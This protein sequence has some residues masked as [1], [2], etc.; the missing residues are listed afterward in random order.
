MRG[1][2]MSMATQTNEVDAHARP[3]SIRLTQASNGQPA[4]SIIGPIPLH[5]AEMYVK[6]GAAVMLDE[7]G[8]EPPRA[9]AIPF[10]PRNKAIN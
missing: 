2:L 9:K 7:D 6:R 1:R 10:A 4:G 5:L 8:E 3:V